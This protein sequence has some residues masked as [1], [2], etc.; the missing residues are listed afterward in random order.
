MLHVYILEIETHWKLH[1]DLEES[2]TQNAESFLNSESCSPFY[3]KHNFYIKLSLQLY[4]KNPI[5]S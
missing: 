1:N 3:N 5:E 4:M 2:S